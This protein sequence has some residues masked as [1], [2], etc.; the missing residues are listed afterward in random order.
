MADWLFIL[1]L[2]LLCGITLILLVLLHCKAWTYG[3]VAFTAGLLSFLHWSKTFPLGLNIL[4]G[5]IL[6]LIILVSINE[7]RKS[8][9]ISFF[10]HIYRECMLCIV[11]SVH[12]KEKLLSFHPKELPWRVPKGFTNTVY[13][14]PDASIE[15]LKPAGAE[16]Q[17]RKI[18]YQI[19][20][21]GFRSP[22]TNSYRDTAVKLSRIA[23][24]ADVAS[25]D[26]RYV[27]KFTYPAALEDA[28]NGL[29]LLLGQGYRPENMIFFGDSAGANIAIALMLKL[30]DAGKK[31]PG[32]A[33]FMSPWLDLS[34]SGESYAFYQYTDPELALRDGE[35][36]AESSIQVLIAYAGE[37]DPTD[38][39]VSPMYGT[40]EKFPPMLILSGSE[41]IVN[42]DSRRVVEKI[43]S[44]GGKVEFSVYHG[45]F[46][47]FPLMLGDK[48]REG[49]AAWLEIE[50]FIKRYYDRN[51]LQPEPVRMMVQRK[52]ITN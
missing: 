46:H 41:E 48:T 28:E 26:Y 2:F 1:I 22:L 51:H 37:N 38:P 17:N 36:Y 35:S 40:F 27:P 6:L 15:I 32:T 24:G 52:I 18:I 49:A 23:D 5:L 19:H 31:L 33:V 29:N 25:L 3:I 10:A 45:M 21:G 39:Y 43:R 9:N 34:I 30:R 44:V 14:L 47:V 20:G 12:N 16:N 42:S 50:K 7:S 8:K 4:I 13:E 11:K